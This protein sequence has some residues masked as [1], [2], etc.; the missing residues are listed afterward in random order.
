MV[1]DRARLCT[2]ANVRCFGMV[3]RDLRDLIGS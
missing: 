2:E 1:V 3:S